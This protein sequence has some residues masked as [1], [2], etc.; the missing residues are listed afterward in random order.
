M[1]EAKKEKKEMPPR[2][3]GTVILAGSA[4]MVA[5]NLVVSARL[6]EYYRVLFPLAGSSRRSGYS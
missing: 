1:S 4:M 6:H 3:R 2:L 5:L